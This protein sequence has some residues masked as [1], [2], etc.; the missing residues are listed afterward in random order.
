[1]NCRI[2]DIKNQMHLVEALHLMDSEKRQHVVVAFAGKIGGE[3]Y[4]A[5]CKKIDEYG[6]QENFRF[7]G[8]IDSY[9]LLSVSDMSFLP[10][11]SEGFALSVVESF[12]MKVPAARTATAGYEDMKDG[13]WLIDADD[14]TPT[15]ELI[16]KLV[17]E[18]K[19][20]FQEKTKVAYELA[21]N[22]FTIERMTKETIKAYEK[23][24]G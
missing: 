4:E 11:K 19:A 1:M 9:E 10:S 23:A 22:K 12:F 14:Y 20:A 8:W 24:I 15:I 18:G 17:D 21:W 13:V 7:V 3:Y 2:S 16:E 6:L 5:L